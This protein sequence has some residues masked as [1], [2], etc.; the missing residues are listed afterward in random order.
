[1]KS[2]NCSAL[3]HRASW[4]PR[5]KISVR[6][7]RALSQLAYQPWGKGMNGHASSLLSVVFGDWLKLSGWAKRSF[8]GAG[9][10]H[11]LTSMLLEAQSLRSSALYLLLRCVN[12]LI[13]PR[14]CR[15]RPVVAA[16]LFER[17]P[18]GE[19]GGFSHGDIRGFSAL[20]VIAGGLLPKTLARH[21]QRRT[22]RTPT[23]RPAWAGADARLISSEARTV[24]NIKHEDLTLVQLSQCTIIGP[25]S[26]T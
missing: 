15:F 7:T 11:F 12:F 2:S 8:C 20:L 10:G 14:V 25:T 4:R 23:R 17:F 6:S 19:F 22:V 5:S 21:S 13:A 9:A 26:M 18:N 24:S 3:A 1:M 16:Q